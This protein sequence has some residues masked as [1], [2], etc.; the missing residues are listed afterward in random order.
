MRTL[1]LIGKISGQYKNKKGNIINFHHSSESE[2]NT[3][4]N[5]NN[6]NTPTYLYLLIYN[7]LPNRKIKNI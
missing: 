7:Y 2:V 4:N 3:S 5:W 1:N 6:V